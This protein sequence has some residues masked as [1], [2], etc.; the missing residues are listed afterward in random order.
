MN[1]REN[2]KI[3]EYLSFK[4]ADTFKKEKGVAYLPTSKL[5]VNTKYI[6]CLKHMND[7]R[8]QFDSGSKHAAAH[9]IGEISGYKL[10]NPDVSIKEGKKKKTY[11]GIVQLKRWASLPDIDVMWTPKSSTMHYKDISNLSDMGIDETSLEWQTFGTTEDEKDLSL[12]VKESE[13][14]IAKKLN[15]ES[16]QIKLTIEIVNLKVTL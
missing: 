13:A 11:R 4:N 14:A 3:L 16:D 10:T 7:S 9:F 15:L 8:C 2:M 5:R 1:E 12:I 6:I